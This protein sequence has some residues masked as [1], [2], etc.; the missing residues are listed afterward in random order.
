MTSLPNADVRPVQCAGA[1]GRTLEV[2]WS[3]SCENP[4]GTPQAIFCGTCFLRRM[5]ER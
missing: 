4:D 2:S 3:S 5:E 1:C